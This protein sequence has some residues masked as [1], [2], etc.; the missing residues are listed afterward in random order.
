M[1]RPA[2]L[3]CLALLVGSCAHAPPPVA[4]SRTESPPTASI[5]QTAHPLATQAALKMLD[6]GGSA[7]DAAIA[8][9]M[10]L[11]LVEPQSSGIGGGSIALYWDAR[12]RKLTSFDGLATAP[13]RA[14]PALDID[15]DGSQ[16]D[17]QAALRGGR[18]VGVPGTLAVLRLAHSRFGRLAW[19]DLF[20]PAIALAE[21]GFPVP[22]YLHELLERESVPR[23]SADM[24][25]IFFS[26]DG[27][28]LATGTMLRNPDY[29][30]TLRRIADVG[31]ERWL[32][33]GGAAAFA[34]AAQG[35]YRPSLMVAQDLLDYRAL[36]RE[37]ICGVFLVYTVCV[38]APPAHGGQI[39]LQILQIAEA[40]AGGRFDFSDPAFVHVFAEASKIGQ[41][42]RRRYVGDPAFVAVPRDIY[43]LD[44]AR[45]RAS[46]IRDVAEQRASAARAGAEE[47]TSQ[48][49]IADRDGSVLTFTTTINL[50]FGAGLMA[51]GYVLNN[52][53]NLFPPAP[54]PGETIPNR[55]EARKRPTTGMAPVIVL[56]AGGN[57]VAAGGSAGGGPIPDY[58][59]QVLVEMLANGRT[60]ATALARGH[61]T[62]FPRG[63]LQLEKD[64]EIGALAPALRARGHV[65]EEVR[66]LSGLGFIRREAGGWIGAA[67]P[68][69]DGDVAGR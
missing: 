12:S 48:L 11:G 52:A 23:A 26:A 69:R 45:R 28:P 25:R 38:M 66:L 6:A 1:R 22:A 59:A 34:A 46:E 31:P 37:P 9:Q 30:R 55:L 61:L 62:S 51:D 57:V 27:K 54:L 2:L 63:K 40:R 10:V 35:G 16:L 15:V 32:A 68:R 18:A 67:D 64:T 17:K 49:T 24:R 5:V 58:V 56:D 65:V 47:M 21:N 20:A 44:Y 42:D 7:I 60:P 50:N 8:A 3:A 43:S 41:A 4:S 53:M 39:V 14:T 36:E 13:S 19:R 29:A 33:E